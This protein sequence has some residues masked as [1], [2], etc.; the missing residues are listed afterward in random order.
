[1]SIDMVE[2]EED[3]ERWGLIPYVGEVLNMSINS[4]ITTI[5]YNIYIYI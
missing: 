4:Y 2:A 3:F 5:Y 1:M